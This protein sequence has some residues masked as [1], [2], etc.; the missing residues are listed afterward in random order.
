MLLSQHLTE[1]PLNFSSNVQVCII[2]IPE[3]FFF[4]YICFN[5]YMVQESHY[6]QETAPVDKKLG[7]LTLN[8]RFKKN[9]KD[10]IGQE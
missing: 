9:S 3:E 10:D 4:L 6:L 5:S 2:Y 1:C 7:N 8:P